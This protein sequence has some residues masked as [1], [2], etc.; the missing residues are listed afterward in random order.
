M[1]QNVQKPLSFP[2]FCFLFYLICKKTFAPHSLT[3]NENKVDLPMDFLTCSRETF[4]QA[5]SS[6]LPTAWP[7]HNLRTLKNL[8]VSRLFHRSSRDEYLLIRPPVEVYVYA[9]FLWP[10]QWGL[11][12]YVP[13]SRAN[14]GAKSFEEK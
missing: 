4:T 14:I 12:V 9:H 13:P 7:P 6:I 8:L 1:K 10:P 11:F 2:F 3:S 5:W